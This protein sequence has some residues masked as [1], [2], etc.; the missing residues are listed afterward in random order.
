MTLTHILILLALALIYLAILPHTWR[1]WALFVGSILGIY[2]LQPPIVLRWVDFAFP[3]LTLGLVGTT[4]LMTRAPDQRPTREDGLAAGLM[5]GL[6]VLLSFGRYL[7]PAYRLTPSTPPPPALVAGVLAGF[8]LILAPLARYHL[9]ARLSTILILLIVGLFV[10][11]KTEPL[12]EAV[13]RQLRAWE[14]RSLKLARAAELQWLGFS[15]V[16]FR[17]IH[18]LR[19]RQTGR[20]PALSLREYATYAVFLPA[21]TAGPIDRAERFLSDWRALPTLI[22]W[23]AARLTQGLARIA[24]GIGKKFVIADT[25]AL[26]ALE[27]AK[28][29]QASS[30]AGLWV[31]LYLY[32]FQI[33]FDFSGYSDIAIGLG[34]LFGIKLPENFNQPYLKRNITTFWQSWHMTLSQWVRAY[35]FLPLSRTLLNQQ[36]AP[37]P[38]MLALI[39]QVTTMMVIGLW[40]GFTWGFAVW[41]LWH[42]LG[43]FAHRVWSDKTRAFYIGLRERPRLNRLLGL[44]GTLITFHFVALGWVWFALPDI[45]SSWAVLRGLFGM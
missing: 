9:S 4:W 42:G 35:V 40:H 2:A 44:A 43:L 3:T 1:G 31:L 37:S 25:L 20:L 32:A 23:D 28:A 18:T 45:R 41:G 17:L 38:V 30:A 14:G 34:Q 36:R 7:V 16:A 8:A 39:G 26:M 27:P 22:G 24:V 19:D 10:V 21:F 5:I 6:I 12:A 15:Y 33:Y 29:A 11:L 13:S